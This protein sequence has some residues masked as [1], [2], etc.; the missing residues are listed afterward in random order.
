[1]FDSITGNDG[2]EVEFGPRYVMKLEDMGIFMQCE[3]VPEKAPTEVSSMADDNNFKM[4]EIK[5]P[6]TVS[7][8]QGSQSKK[9]F[10]TSSSQRRVTTPGSG[11]T[12]PIRGKPIIIDMNKSALPEERED[13]DLNYDVSEGEEEGD[14][15][16]GIENE[17]L[18]KLLEKP[19]LH[20]FVKGRI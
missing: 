17:W 20:E 14:L 12:A 2:E 10:G 11:K 7:L 5:P 18:N 13:D 6:Q 16:T 15:D 1:M 3:V 8:Q 9:G 19:P 4:P